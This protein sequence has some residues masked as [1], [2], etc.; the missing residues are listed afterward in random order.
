MID[1]LKVFFVVLFCCLALDY[2]RRLTKAA[3]IQCI[4]LHRIEDRLGNIQSLL[5]S[6]NAKADD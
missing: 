6:I 1:F 2:L 4:S 3:T 5:S